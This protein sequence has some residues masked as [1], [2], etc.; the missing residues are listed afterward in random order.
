MFQDGI[1]VDWAAV[2]GGGSI[3]ASLATL[4]FVAFN[5]GKLTQKVEGHSEKF[6]EQAKTNI[7]VNEKLSE[8][9][10]AISRLDAYDLA[11]R[12]HPQGADL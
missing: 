11:G 3:I 8:H 4:V 10:N 2:T 1:M 7:Y 6:N 5:G 12:H 9:G